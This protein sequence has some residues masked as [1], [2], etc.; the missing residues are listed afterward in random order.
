MMSPKTPASH[1][2]EKKPGDFQRR[3]DN[4]FLACSAFA[5]AAALLAASPAEAKI[6]YSGVKNV[7][8][9]ANGTGLSIDL[10]AGAFSTTE[11]IA[12]F[13]LKLDLATSTRTRQLK[14]TGGS[15]DADGAD[16]TIV[17]THSSSSSSSSSTTVV[18]VNKLTANKTVSGDSKFANLGNLGTVTTGSS[19]S[20]SS[21]SGGGPTASGPW[22]KG[23]SGYVGFRFVSAANTTLYGWA[24][25]SVGADLQTTVVDWAYDD[26]GQP[27][28]AGQ[29]LDTVVKVSVT[30]P[31][32]AEGGGNGLI[33]FVR[34]GDRS[35][36]LTVYYQVKSSSTA[37][38]GVDYP[39]LSGTV[40][41]AAGKKAAK[42]PISAVNNLT[43]DGTRTVVVKVLPGHGYGVE[44][45]KNGTVYIT[46][47]D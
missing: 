42:L 30:Q 24:Q 39:T 11:E 12:G 15:A 9:P 37:V 28:G 43:K 33:R 10:D 14:F 45:P 16:A 1:P 13:D 8:V 34:S 2:A 35:Q 25:L 19:S 20:S 6:V 17:T 3:L 44:K 47:N 27:I 31:T 29:T 46:D 41:I 38:A 4:H 32:A 36:P 7:T 21:S 5:G 22:G 18:S 40:T 23:G 26:S